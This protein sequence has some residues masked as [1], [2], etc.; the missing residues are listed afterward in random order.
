MGLNRSHVAPIAQKGQCSSKARLT[1]DQSNLSICYEGI[2]RH[3][4]NNIVRH[5]RRCFVREFPK[6]FR[7]K[8]KKPFKA[9]EWDAIVKNSEMCRCTGEISTEIKDEFDLLSVNHFFNIF[10][11]QFDIL[12]PSDLPRDP[13][14]VSGGQA[15]DP[16]RARLRQTLLQWLKTVKT[17]RDPISHPSEEDLSYEDAFLVLD[18]GRRTLSALKLDG[19]ERVRELMQTLRGRPLSNQNR[20]YSKLDFLLGKQS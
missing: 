19:A 14:K 10:E 9:E 13:Q 7:E 20:K 12:V 6:D 3:Y 11:A 18:C 8:L 15:R 5:I 4:R 1:V 2:Q 17:F 16:Q